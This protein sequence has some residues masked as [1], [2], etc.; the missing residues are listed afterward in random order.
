M[1]RPRLLLAGAAAIA[2]TGSP[3]GEQAVALVLFVVIGCLGVAT[4]L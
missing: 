1:P 4:P 3:A 2:Q